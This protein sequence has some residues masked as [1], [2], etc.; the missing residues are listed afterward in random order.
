[1]KPLFVQRY[2]VQQDIPVISVSSSGKPIQSG[3]VSRGEVVRG[4]IN[5]V[6]V[7]RGGKKGKLELLQ[8][9]TN[10][11]IVPKYVIME[12][13]SSAEGGE[14]IIEKDKKASFI[15]K[16]LP[17][18]GLGIG[19]YYAHKSRDYGTAVNKTAAY[20][21]YAALGLFAGAL[22]ILIWS[23]NKTQAEFN[24]KTGRV[25]DN[26]KSKEYTDRAYDL[27]IKLGK[28]ADKNM[29]L[30]KEEFSK[31]FDVLTAKEKEAFVFM[32]EQTA[33][34]PVKDS[35]K[36]VAGICSI[37]KEASEKFGSEVIQSLA[38]KTTLPA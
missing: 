14:M 25:A 36:Y 6:N 38:D 8:I 35:K 24:K 21:G 19:L 13:L 33:K 20:L 30:D 27:L 34:L 28:K 31:Q 2:Q 29:M 3:K 10:K 9:A 32:A 16:V 17:F 12:S 18:V 23:Y 37:S 4:I 15:L 26:Q 7:N 5:T 1:M 11:Y 22:P